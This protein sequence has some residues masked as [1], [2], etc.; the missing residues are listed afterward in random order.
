[1]GDSGGVRPS[2]VRIILLALLA[3]CE[4]AAA[5]SFAEQQQHDVEAA[6][7]SRRVHAFFYLWYG[8]PE[9]DGQWQHWNHE[10]LS[11][12]D[13]SVRERYPSDGMRYLPPGDVHSPFYP[14]RGCYSS[15]DAQ[16]TRAQ[17]AE[18]LA[19]GVGVVVL[20]WSGRPD[21]PGTHDTQG[22]STDALIVAVMDIAQEVGMKVA[23]HLEPYEGR[24]AMTVSD[25]F[26]YII[27]NFGP[28]PA[29]HRIAT[30]RGKGDEREL[31]VVYVY[32][33]YRIPIREWQQVLQPMRS[34]SVRNSARDVFAI[35]L[36]LEAHDGHQLFEAGFDGA[37]TYFASDGFTYGSTT[38]NWP[39]MAKI[40][41]DH[42][43]LFIPSVGPG[44]DDT[45]IRPW[46]K[47]TRRDRVGGRYYEEM[48]SSA[49]G[50]GAAVVSITSYNEWGEGTQI[51]PAVPRSVQPDTAL[52]PE[53]R[54]RLELP[55]AYSSYEPY[56]AF[57]YLNRTARWASFLE[58]HLSHTFND[59]F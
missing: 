7:R 6:V 21:L 1:M 30:G 35:G 49:I 3:I 56:D 40:A 12:W 52:A 5:Y 31:P 38:R 42:R 4:P 53:V 45:K 37:Y 18:L 33:S 17:L 47:H 44:Y 46:N 10:V 14:M 22:I 48:W 59:E 9:V 36:W 15:R 34:N 20:S 39:S 2:S 58:T 8:T 28:H 57:F 13:T 26:A 32:D 27:Q 51:E 24:S 11:H 43:L 55:V 54:A 29:L 50:A 19:A 25:D 41:A 16:V 23:L